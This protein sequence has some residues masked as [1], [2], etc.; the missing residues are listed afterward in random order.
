MRFRSLFVALA[1]FK[2]CGLVLFA[3]AKVSKR[4]LHQ[5]CIANQAIK[6]FFESV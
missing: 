2:D 3:V 5:N 1:G 6:V 4:L